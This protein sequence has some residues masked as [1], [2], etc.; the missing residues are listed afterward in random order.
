MFAFDRLAGDLYALGMKNPDGR[1]GD[2]D[3]TRE[4]FRS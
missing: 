4:V 2:R 1:K 3:Y